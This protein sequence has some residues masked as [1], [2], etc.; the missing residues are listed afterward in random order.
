MAA[1]EYVI[2]SIT[3]F[4]AV[5]LPTASLIF[6]CYKEFCGLILVQLR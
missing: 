3:Q 4:H 6:I 2:D 5:K 1:L